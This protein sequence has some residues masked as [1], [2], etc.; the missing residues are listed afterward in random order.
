MTNPPS[1]P[2]SA[3]SLLLIFPTMAYEAEIRSYRAEFLEHGENMA[4]TSG[5]RYAES[6]SEW[7]AELEEQRLG[8][9]GEL[10]QATTYL[11]VRSSD[12]RIVGMVNIRHHL[13]DYLRV[14][15]GHIGYS[16]RRSERNRGYGKQ[17]LAL[18]LDECRQ[19]K[20]KKV[21]I[22]CDKDNEASRAVILA[23]GGVYSRDV[24]D[25]GKTT[26][27][28]WIDLLGITRE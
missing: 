19:L 21:M 20:L 10:V 23:N 8:A 12:Q 25:D 28:F 17:Q 7:I 4:G 26:Q 24:I 27:I 11:C 16:I 15:G 9:V 5:L 22:T 6:V 1:T 18:A 3:D 13:N 2:T 14:S